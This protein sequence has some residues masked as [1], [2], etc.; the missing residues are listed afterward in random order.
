MGDNSH[1]EA[2]GK[3]ENIVVANFLRRKQTF[4]WENAWRILSVTHIYNMYLYL[5]CRH[6]WRQHSGNFGNYH[7]RIIFIG[8]MG[9]PLNLC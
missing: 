9:Q 4:D 8:V 6:A 2:E 5:E 1:S 7:T 3:M